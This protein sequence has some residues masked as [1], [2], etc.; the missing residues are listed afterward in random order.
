MNAARPIFVQVLRYTAVLAL[1]IAV[2]GGGV[3]Y[4][5][6]GADGL[7]SALLGTALAVVFAAITAASMLVAIRFELAAFFGIVMGAWLLKLVI[8]IA[9]LLLVRDQPFV[10][11]VVL[12]LS[13]VVSIVGTLAID[14]LVVVRGRLS[15]VSDATL[16][17]APRD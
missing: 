1:V 13:L 17:A 5:V 7:W 15:H 9:L 11:D 10:N 12:F 4:L 16:P 6:A 14:A 2:V 8:F 3:G